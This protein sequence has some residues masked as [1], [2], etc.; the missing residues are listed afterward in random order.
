MMAQTIDSASSNGLRSLASEDLSAKNLLSH[1]NSIRLKSKAEPA[2][3]ETTSMEGYLAHHRDM[4][5]LTA[6]D[7]SRRR[8]DEYLESSRRRWN[9][10]EWESAKATFMESLGHRA[11]AW[12]K[13][14][15]HNNNSSG[16]QANVSVNRGL[17]PMISSDV[18]P[19]F[20]EHSLAVRQINM[21]DYSLSESGVVPA[22]EI[23]I[24]KAGLLVADEG[25]MSD[26][27]IA[28]YK[29]TLEMLRSMVGEDSINHGK[30]CI[31]GQFASVCFDGQIVDDRKQSSMHQTL[32][33]GTQRFLQEKVL[34]QWTRTVGQGP[35]RGDFGSES[36]MPGRN[37][38]AQVRSYVQYLCS[39]NI[40]PPGSMPSTSATRGASFGGS[41]SGS[42]SL[43]SPSAAGNRAT[44]L[45]FWP[46]IYHCLR[47]GQIRV[48]LDELQ[49]HGSNTSN[50]QHVLI[51]NV[52]AVIQILSSASNALDTEM[53][54][55]SFAGRGFGRSKL[56]RDMSTMIE[57]RDIK[58]I[59][60]S[61]QEQYRLKLYAA[62]S[63]NNASTSLDPYLLAVLNL[64]SGANR[65][66]FTELQ[67]PYLPP[68]FDLFD[69]MWTNLWFIELDA[70]IQT[71]Y[72]QG[73][74]SAEFGNS[75]RSI[76]RTLFLD[77]AQSVGSSGDGSSKQ[78]EDEFVELVYGLA[79][80]NFFDRQ[81]L[82][83]MS[84]DGMYR[85]SISAIFRYVLAL[86]ACHRFGDAI[87]YLW[88]KGQ[89]F[90]AVHLTILALHYGLILP[91]QPLI[92]NP[93]MPLVQHHF[94]SHVASVANLTPMTILQLYVSHQYFKNNVTLVTDYLATLILSARYSINQASILDVTTKEVWKMQAEEK[95]ADLFE[96]FVMSLEG[97]DSVVVL[98]GQG[99]LASTYRMPSKQKGHLSE[100]RS[101]KEVT[102]H[103]ERI[104]NKFRR[105]R[106]A[107][108][109]IDFFLLAGNMKEVIIEYCQQL[110]MN[111]AKV[112]DTYVSYYHSQSTSSS[113]SSLG[114]RKM[115]RESAQRFVADY[116][117]MFVHTVDADQ[118]LREYRHFMKQLLTLYDAVDLLL[119][120]QNP[121]DALAVIDQLQIL[122]IPSAHA[123]PTVIP[124]R[125]VQTVLDDLIL[126][127]AQC[128][129]T[130][131]Q[132]LQRQ[133]QARVLGGVAASSTALTISRSEGSILDVLKLRWQ[134]LMDFARDTKRILQNPQTVLDLVQLDTNFKW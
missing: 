45:P 66:A 15:G 110:A 91:H 11:Q 106:D 98:L 30:P 128:I 7:E 55:D 64:V 60:L 132:Q 2:R 35:N 29:L 69:L 130:L 10:R 105:N 25:F 22:C 85:Q 17:L 95:A 119:L 18:P 24:E 129:V 76:R 81:D 12:A 80:E 3:L 58:A 39:S 26:N 65:A 41:F 52:Q 14:S 82:R 124:N 114:I 108:R 62:T 8:S 48:A 38:E 36:R 50:P 87:Q 113:S 123:A 127:V 6:I 101:D 47:S 13:F 67:S 133:V 79:S 86:F 73:L 20:A 5:V 120:E 77:Q 56:S 46:F 70:A 28:G 54:D 51:Q 103:I 19:V 34:E 37:K 96:A 97:M 134:L 75:S 94:A 112:D 9:A 53:S 72:P 68:Q 131:Y 71:Q 1:V 74:F 107:R 23:L 42:F 111:W 125:L 122:P 57:A 21:T 63:S 117:D 100:Y 121:T 93:L 83:A 31:P 116:D 44:N 99:Q 89:V 16:H 109:A 115:W 88:M 61:L 32:R 84:V 40:L 126:F 102:I 33:K 49:E 118:E 59:L 90:A 78:G 27:D 104:A 43:S 92:A 4:I